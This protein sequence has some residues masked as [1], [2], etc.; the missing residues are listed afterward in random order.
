MNRAAAVIEGPPL[1]PATLGP[2]TLPAFLADVAARFDER[3]A[4]VTGFGRWSYRQLYERSVAATV[5]LRRR[6]VGFGDRV[7][8]VG[9]N[10]EPWISA[11]FGALRLG[12]VP[13]LL[14]ALLTIE[15]I[16]GAI[17]LTGSRFLL[18]SGRT[19]SRTIMEEYVA[20]HPSLAS[21]DLNL[22]GQAIQDELAALIEVSGGEVRAAWRW[23]ASGSSPSAEDA[24]ADP[25]APSDEALVLFTS[26]TSGAP[27]AVLH[28]HH[29]PCLQYQPWVRAQGIN[30][31]DR[32]FTAYPFCWSSGFVRSLC[33]TLST[34]ARL[35]TVDRFE[36]E[37]VLQLMEEEQVTLA[38]LP[39]AHLEHRLLDSD[40]FAPARL[41]T[42]RSATPALAQALEIPTLGYAAYG[43][44]ETFTLVT[45][46]CLDDMGPRPPGWV[47]PPLPGWTIRVVDDHT[48]HLLGRGQAGRIEVRG[49]SM[50]R[51][52]I[53]RARSDYLTEDG[54]FRT[55]D[56]G[57]LDDRGNLS[58]LGRLDDVIRASGAN[59]ST[60]EVEQSLLNH[61][62]IRLAVALGVPHPRLGQALIACVVPAQEALD[63]A[64]V[65]AWLRGRLASYK[66][67][68]RVL[69][70]DER[71]L[72]FTVSQKVERAHLRDVVAARLPASADW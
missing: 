13:V 28:E 1:A 8:V 16:D 7:A 22:M 42:L 50:M 36:P 45:L 52:Y 30:A 11:V 27:K 24:P 55:P 23:E 71:E 3:Q 5:A 10:G 70:F 40:A 32:V 25:V 57:L 54:F 15:D 69:V 9:A 12:A 29:A 2:Q 65:L 6:G 31:D 33:A 35:V 44:T 34:G 48:G 19:G 67:P 49:P 61:P 20:R 41:R 39:A 56:S 66:V 62:Q 4:L 68:R 37:V 26:G 72:R 53:G 14:H 60:A 64:E 51:E 46:G 21:A 18:I 17:A 43:M 63:E 38:V 47:G 58:F 59:V